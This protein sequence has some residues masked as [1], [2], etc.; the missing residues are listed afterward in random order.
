MT[1]P[2]IMPQSLARWFAASA[3]V[4]V[5]ADALAGWSFFGGMKS[6]SSSLPAPHRHDKSHKSSW[7]PP[8]RQQNIQAPRGPVL[9]L[10]R[11]LLPEPSPVS[12][13]WSDIHIHTHDHIC[14]HATEG[15]PR[16][17]LARTVV[18]TPVAR[19]SPIPESHRLGRARARARARIHPHRASNGRDRCDIAQPGLPSGP[20]SAP[21]P[22]TAGCGAVSS[23]TIL[24]TGK[25]V[26]SG[27]L[28]PG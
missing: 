11:D 26:G 21:A 24:G 3:P 14:V 22:D 15:R 27:F 12:L 5:P 2:E 13:A 28:R 23:R 20:K 18:A 10:R 25:P 16:T 19:G 7:S 17:P 8:N 9:P 4:E 6:K 1:C